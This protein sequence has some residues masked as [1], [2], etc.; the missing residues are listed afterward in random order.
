MVP[1]RSATLAVLAYG[2]LTGLKCGPNGGGVFPEP[3]IGRWDAIP[4][5]EL[6]RLWEE[7]QGSA[8][9]LAIEPYTARVGRRAAKKK[10]WAVADAGLKFFVF[11]DQPIWFPADVVRRTVCGTEPRW[12]YFWHAASFDESDLHPWLG[13]EE[14]FRDLLGDNGPALESGAFDLSGCDEVG[15]TDGRS[16]FYG[17]VTPTRGFDEWFCGGRGRT[18]RSR[19]N[20]THVAT[21]PDLSGT[22][23]LCLHGPFVLERVHGWRPEIHP[24]EVIWA[25]R[26][27]AR[28]SWTFALV[29]DGSGRFDKESHYEKEES[30]E[31]WKPWSSARPIELWV[32]F[33]RDSDQPLVFDLAMKVLGKEMSPARQVALAPPPAGAAFSVLANE[34]PGV[35]TA[36][37]A[38]EAAAGGERGFLV[39]RAVM[40]KKAKEALVLRLS[41]R[42]ADEEPPPAEIESARRPPAVLER[43][44]APKVR[45]FGETRL[46]T[47]AVGSVAVNTLVRFDPARPAEPADEQATD[48]LNA[49]LGGGPVD[50]SAGAPADKEAQRRA[51]FGTARPFRVEWELTAVR[52]DTG[53]PVRLEVGGAARFVGAP[54]SG[55]VGIATFPGPA[56]EEIV[57]R[58]AGPVEEAV[59]ETRPVSLGQVLLWVPRGVTVT[60][61]ARVRY[62]GTEPLGLPDPAVTVSLRYPPWSYDDEWDLVSDVLGEIDG[63]IAAERLLRLREDA[64]APAP[65]AECT[66]EPLA[67]E[68]ARRLEDPVER[69]A[70]LRELGSGDRPHARLVWLFARALRWDGRVT[71][72]EREL[73]K[74]LLAPA[75]D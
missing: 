46:Q 70:T 29:P 59:P 20:A 72:E 43:E 8:G 69:W 17:E 30:R 15:G 14:S 6:D 52:D 53:E 22:E 67:P 25:R 48:R 42:L 62:V 16:C 75:T 58:G 55:H 64:C 11:G 37:K 39:I 63:S 56:T 44:A 3:E 51:A 18:C 45:L 47:P 57:V 19:V 7:A 2:L 40:R 36:S 31:S 74:K 50:G 66:K 27:A 9:I 26:G 68:V 10:T 35:A 12:S 65:A 34:L 49:A 5:A 23:M 61:T 71:D 13:S 73:M 4:A 21:P 54:P 24:A 1:W 60:G 38:W 41:G 28:G 32:A 33:S